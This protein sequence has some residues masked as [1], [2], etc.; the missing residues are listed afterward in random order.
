MVKMKTLQELRHDILSNFFVSLNCSSG[1]EKPENNGL[2]RK[3]NTEGLILKQIG[4]TMAEDG[5]DWNGLEMTILKSLAKF[6]SKYKNDDE[7]PLE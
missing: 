7:A 4:T 2:L 1:V 3:K 6:F 5:E